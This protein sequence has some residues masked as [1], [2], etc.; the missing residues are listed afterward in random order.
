MSLKSELIAALPP[1]KNDWQLIS[2][3]QGTG[4]I[5]DEIQ[6]AHEEFKDEYDDIYSFFEA[7]T[8]YNTCYKLWDFQRNELDYVAESGKDQSSR[9]PAAIL[10]L[11]DDCKH[12]A[13]FTSGVLSAMQRDGRVPWTWFYRFASDKDIDYVTHVFVVVVSKGKEIWIDPCIRTFDNQRKQYLITEDVMALYRISGV[14]EVAASKPQ[15]VL[16][17]K[18]IA[19]AR[20]LYM[21]GENMFQLKALMKNTPDV[22]NGPVRQWFINNGYDWNHVVRFINS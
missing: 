10:Q 21:M 12:F 3:K 18:D 5:I 2:K 22:T 4:D 1:F 19:L 9:S 16:V 6:N 14:S 17:D 13:L 20:F 7:D 15:T 8:I 11:P